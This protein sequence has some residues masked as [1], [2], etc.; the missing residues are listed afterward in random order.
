MSESESEGEVEGNHLEG[1]LPDLEEGR[2]LY[3]LVWVGADGGEGAYENEDGNGSRNPNRDNT[4][5][6]Q[7]TPFETSGISDEPVSLLTAD[8]LGAVVHPC[9]SLYDSDDL[10][11]IKRWLVR[12]QS[13][14]D[15]AGDRF[16]TPLPFQF[17][18]ILRGDDGAVREWLRDESDRLREPLEELAGHWEY[19]IEV[20]RTEPIDPAALAADDEQL[21]AL[22]A[23][24][25]GA[26]EGAAFLLEKQYEKRVAELRERRRAA[27]ADELRRRLSGH[28][29]EV[30]ELERE[31]RASLGGA[32]SEQRQGESSETVCRLTLLAHEDR[33]EAIGAVLDDVAAEPG[34]EVRFTGPWPPYTFAPEIGGEAGSPPGASPDGD[35][36]DQGYATKESKRHNDSRGAR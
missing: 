33:E 12:H 31:P 14:I 28:A 13:V 17:D 24:I 9:S 23:K 26:E 29:R 25:E 1:E 30:H 6:T 27:R 36:I 22:E 21:A 3:C 10:G 8:G 16:G 20:A 35:E 32:G 18:T 34:I 2:Y 11:T 7:P 4:T 19:R 15:E 5:D